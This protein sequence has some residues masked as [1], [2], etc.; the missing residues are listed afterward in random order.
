MAPGLLQ[1][2][3]PNHRVQHHIFRGVMYF[4]LSIC[5][6]M[7]I[8]LF[9][10]QR[11]RTDAV[12]HRERLK[13]S[14]EILN[15]EN[16]KVQYFLCNKPDEVPV[17]ELDQCRTDASLDTRMEVLLANS[18]KISK[19]KDTSGQSTQL[20]NWV[21]IVFEFGDGELDWINGKNRIVLLLPRNVHRATYIR[22]PDGFTKQF[23]FA[24]D[25]VFSFTSQE[26]RDLGRIEIRMRLQEQSVPFFGPA[27][28]PAVLA[29]SEKARDYSAL[30]WMQKEAGNLS[31]QFQLGIPVLL[32][33]MA[34]VLDHSSVMAY[35]ALYGASRA[36]HDFIGFKIDSGMQKTII[37]DYLYRMSCGWGFAFLV[38]FTST[39]VGLNVRRIKLSHRWLFVLLMGYLFWLGGKLDPSFVTTSD[40]WGD[41]LSILASFGV[42]VYAGIERLRNPVKAETKANHPDTY[43]RLSVAL[44]VTRLA[45]V[46]VAF[47]IHGWVNVKDLF[48][49]LTEDASLKSPLDWKIMVL[50]PSLMTAALLEVGSTAKKMLTFGK[51]MATK[52]LIERELN[53]GREVQAR[54]L[55]RLKSSTPSWSWR[56]T[57]L[58]AEALGGDW[59]D[60]R[61]LNFADGRTLLVACVADVTGHGVGSSLAT[62]VICSH[63]GLWCESLSAGHFPETSELKQEVLRR[64]PFQI[65][66]GLKA[67]R[68]NENCTA[69]FAIFDPIQNEVTFC[70]AGHPGI[71]CIGPQSF[72][73]FTTQGE[74]LG[75]DFLQESTWKAKTEKINGDELIVLY[76]DGIVPLRATVSSWAA[77]LK[78]KI[79]AGQ[80]KSPEFALVQQLR[81]NKE[82]FRSA[83]DLVDDMTLVMVRRKSLELSAAANSHQADGSDQHRLSLVSQTA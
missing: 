67:L 16:V 40:L 11:S 7:F 69:I 5:V 1:K 29:R 82:G 58:P 71:F 51:E 26:L 79:L 14:G 76:S 75:S 57:Y 30:I 77:Q 34:I 3:V 35:L 17:E 62:S 36:V 27:D 8:R 6:Y 56:A 65:H 19:F 66:S 48:G 60:I 74:R 42:L 46:C 15:L 83:R 61:E 4:A 28:I 10:E 59:F 44:V 13:E 63:W 23:G 52:A 55:P 12:A 64:A 50:M 24:A 73:Y 21:K 20:A 53:V 81:L 47:A 25:S 18:S 9:S 43:S 39:L 38:L 45:L 68:E 54:M 80:V 37:E 70:S 32:A 22:T 41:S 2:L 33:A 49:I 31:R 72:R 78:R